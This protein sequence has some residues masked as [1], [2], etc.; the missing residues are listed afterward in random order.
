VAIGAGDTGARMRALVAC[1]ELG[2]LCFERGGAGIFVV[3]G[4]EADLVVVSGE[5]FDLEAFRPRIEEA[6]LGTLK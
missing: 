3:P 4:T 1:L 5:L 6:L 2:M